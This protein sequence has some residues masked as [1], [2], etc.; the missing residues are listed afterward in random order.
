MIGGDGE[1]VRGGVHFHVSYL[2]ARTR[3]VGSC[4]NVEASFA[5]AV[6]GVGVKRSNV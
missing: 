6:L 2:F 3:K 1:I 5:W 4:Q